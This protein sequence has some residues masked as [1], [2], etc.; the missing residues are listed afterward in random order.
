MIKAT[1]SALGAVVVGLQRGYI[2]PAIV[3]VSGRTASP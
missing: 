3:T 1:Q 2:Q